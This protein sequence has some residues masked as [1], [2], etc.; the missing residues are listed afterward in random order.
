MSFLQATPRRF[1]VNSGVLYFFVVDVFLDMVSWCA[2]YMGP[3]CTMH[4]QT[5]PCRP[6]LGFGAS[7]GCREPRCVQAGPWRSDS[8]IMFN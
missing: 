5:C 7:A 3:M 6:G 1:G 2:C 4:A 8:L